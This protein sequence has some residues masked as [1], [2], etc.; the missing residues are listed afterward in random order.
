[1]TEVLLGGRS[2]AIG[3]FLFQVRENI[4]RKILLGRLTSDR[5]GKFFSRAASFTT[6]RL[7][8]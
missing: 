7:C 3:C 1:M 8:C 2:H 5:R 6:I 4:K